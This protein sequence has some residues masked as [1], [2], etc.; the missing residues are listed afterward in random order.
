MKRTIQ[1]LWALAWM[2][3]AAWGLS[4]VYLRFM[5]GRDLAN[6][7][8]Y[9]PWGL[10]VSAYIYFIGLS[11]GAFLLSSMVYVFRMDMF[12]RLGRLALFTAA[13]TLFMALLAIW[14]DLGQMWRFYE[15]FTRPQ[16]SSMMTWMVWLYTAYFILI[17]GEL[18]YEMRCDV[19]CLAAQGG[20]LGPVYRLLALGWKC[21]TDASELE[22]CHKENHRWLRVLGGIGIPLAIAFHGGVGAL[23]ATLTA[24]PHWH[25]SLFP[26]LFLTGALVSGSALLLSVYAI[27]GTKTRTGDPLLKQ[28]GRWV[29]LLLLL[30]IVLEWAETSVPIWYGVGHGYELTMEILFGRFWYIFWIVHVLLGTLIPAFLLLVGP[31]SRIRAAVAGGLIAVCFLAVRLN[32]VIPGLITPSL[33]GLE[34][35]Y[36][37]PRLMFTY[38]PSMFEWSVVAFLV[39][40]GSGLFFLGRRY[41]P[42]IDV[43]PSA[44]PVAKGEV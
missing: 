14:F 39:A 36:V 26:I 17:L 24:R 29:L 37:D 28:L 35:A 23:F 32:L 30:D 12:A 43:E 16:F 18:W 7:G 3:L 19:A 33:E 11:A 42:L 40:L 41:L 34:E 8:S 9:V 15:I 31:T 38:V 10:W 22:R 13:V 6:Y 5:H 27:Y 44:N 25:Q 2:A 21:P 1:V 4:G 20:A